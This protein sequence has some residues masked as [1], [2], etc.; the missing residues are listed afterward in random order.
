ML[1]ATPGD[2]M[3]VDL[4]ATEVRTMKAGR[5]VMIVLGA[6]LALIGFALTAGGI[7]GLVAYATA[8]TDGRVRSPGHRCPG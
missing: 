7:A 8:R 5:I 6:F 1:Y 2:P 4:R 3:V